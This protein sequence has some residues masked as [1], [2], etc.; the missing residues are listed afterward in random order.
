MR[1]PEIAIADC[2]VKLAMTK[3]FFLGLDRSYIYS[4]INLY[5]LI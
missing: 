4:I 3:R 5:K 1:D 2:F